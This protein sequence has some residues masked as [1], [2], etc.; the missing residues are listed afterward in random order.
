MKQS[1][2]L[3]LEEKLPEFVDALRNGWISTFQAAATVSALF[4]AVAAQ[5]FVFMKAP[6]SFSRETSSGSDKDVPTDIDTPA[7][8]FLLVLA[9]ASIICNCNATLAALAISDRLGNLPYQSQL[10]SANEPKVT[11]IL[12]SEHDV[13]QKFGIGE[14]WPL[15]FWLWYLSFLLGIVTTVA[16]IYVYMYMKE[17]VIVRIMVSFLLVMAGS[18]LWFFIPVNLFA[19]KSSQPATLAT[20]SQTRLVQPETLS[21]PL[22]PCSRRT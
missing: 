12:G 6:G 15:N 1:T 3:N 2:S 14:S 10:L 8:R 13:L 9:Y 16:E 22:L 5:L 19:K 18:H 20:Q 17:S 7:Y 21:T 4:A 11:C